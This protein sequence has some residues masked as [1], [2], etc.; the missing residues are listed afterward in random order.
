[1][2]E[3]QYPI[4]DEITHTV[5][6]LFVPYNV[7]A[8]P[9]LKWAGGKGQLL[10]KFQ[11]LYP[12]QLKKNRIKTFY[13][14]F[15]GSGAVFFDVVQHYDIESAYLYD[16][17]EEL[18]LTYKV[19]QKDVSKLLDFLHRY[20]K[21]YA[22]L[23]KEQR[24]EF[25]Y[26]QRTNYNLQRFNTDYNKYSDMWFPRAA[27]LI[28]LNRTCFNGLYRVNSKGEF[29]SPVGD[30][31]NPTICDERN[32][33]AVHQVLQIAEIK[34]ADFKELT[35]DLRESS[36]VYFDPPYRPISKTANFNAYSKQNFADTEQI[37]LAQ[38]FMQLD[39]RGTQVMLSNSDPKNNDPSDNFFD[40]IYKD[41]NILR[42]PAKRMIN[43][44]AAKRG[45]INE[46][47]VTN[48]ATK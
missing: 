24:K 21:V 12:N 42:V 4:Y 39:K 25:Y 3:V 28:F 20:Q 17:N 38:L 15:L 7:G 47:V 9:F 31:D 32:L 18:I 22:K 11:K 2:E 30:Y 16:I 27:Q 48:Y 13:E 23:N 45:A 34:K 43:S 10:D 37:Q 5:N 29:N 1:M 35:Y 19:I 40:E 33:L 14:P 41:F 6:D 46:I 36:F 44:N 26:D 8:R